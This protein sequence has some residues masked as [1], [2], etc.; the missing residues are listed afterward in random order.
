MDFHSFLSAV[1]NYRELVKII[2]RGLLLCVF[3]SAYVDQIRTYVP[4]WQAMLT[5]FFFFFLNSQIII[6]EQYVLSLSLFLSLSLTLCVCVCVHACVR[7]CVRTRARVCVCVHACVCVC[8]RACVRARARAHVN[9]SS[10]LPF[11]LILFVII[12]YT[13]CISKS[14]KSI[15]LLLLLLP[16]EFKNIV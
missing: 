8:V 14:Q 9:S 1:D 13:F 3:A 15:L 12:L 7:A 10:I 5:V 2:R 4:L 6:L 11:S 16:T